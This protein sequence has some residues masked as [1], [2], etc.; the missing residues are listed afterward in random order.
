MLSVITSFRAGLLKLA[1][2]VSLAGAAGCAQAT[3][4][5]RTIHG[6]VT[7]FYLPRGMCDA[8]DT[9]FGDNLMFVLREKTKRI[10]DAPEPILVFA[11]CI[12]LDSFARTQSP[13]TWGYFGYARFPKQHRAVFNQKLFNE[14]AGQPPL[15]GPGVMLVHG[16]SLL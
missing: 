14:M 16:R 11:D 15:S 9:L 10:K 5:T 4:F 7:T 8:T 6:D 2:A 1:I 12:S 13:R 3:S